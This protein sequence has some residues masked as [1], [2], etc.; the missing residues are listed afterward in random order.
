MYCR[1]LKYLHK[2][3][4]SDTKLTNDSLQKAK[5]TA[6]KLHLHTNYICGLMIHCRI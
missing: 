4:I 3:Y 5:T 2:N 1:K 6:Q